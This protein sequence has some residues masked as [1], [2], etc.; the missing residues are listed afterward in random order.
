MTTMCD[1]RVNA[2]PR[3]RGLLSTEQASDWLGVSKSWLDKA[4]VSGD[5]PRFCRVG[6]LVRYREC[7][8]DAY[9]DQTSRL[10][11]SESQA[12]LSARERRD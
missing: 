5:G 6:R 10:S 2:P 3:F 9:L 12:R 1:G 7:D 11:T 8:L 4:R